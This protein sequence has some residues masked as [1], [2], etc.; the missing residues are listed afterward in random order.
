M[1]SLTP[2]QRDAL[3][4]E[5]QRYAQEYLESLPPEHFME[6]TTQGYQREVT[7]ASLRLICVD[8]PD[9]QI[10]NELLVQYGRGEGKKPGQVVPD[11]MVVLH[12]EPVVAVGSYDTVLQPAP[13]FWVLEYVSKSSKR[14]DYE[15]NMVKYEKELKVPY[16]L[17]FYPDADELSLFHRKRGRY[18]S[19]KPNERDRLPLPELDLEMA[20]HEGWVR[21][22]FREELLPL[23]GDLRRSL[24]RV[25]AKLATANQIIRQKDNQLDA[26]QARLAAAEAELRRARGET[27]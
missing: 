11:N 16:Y 2:T 12:A 10:F 8:R 5:Y 17:R 6:A 26:M 3:E 24:R 20:L 18:V 25:E 19:V 15:D 27:N 1:A 4:R 9:V 23:T 7:L 13:P 22:W 21:Y 14:K